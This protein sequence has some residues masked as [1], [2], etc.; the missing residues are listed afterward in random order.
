MAEPRHADLTRAEEALVEQIAWRVGDVIC[1][2][3]EKRIDEKIAQHLADC[4]TAAVVKD[5]RARAGGFILAFTLI[6]G[7]LGAVLMVAGRAVWNELTRR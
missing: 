5:F 4:T 3:I 6:G 2:R 1:K 7:F